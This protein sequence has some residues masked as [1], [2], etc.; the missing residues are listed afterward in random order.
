MTEAADDLEQ[1]RRDMR[2]V[3]TSRDSGFRRF[4]DKI[5]YTACGLVLAL[6]GTVWGVTWLATKDDVSDLKKKSQEHAE[7]ITS[8]ETEMKSLR[9][10]VQEVKSDVKLILREV[11]K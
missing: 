1:T 2:R 9:S 4:S 3:D 11:K 10:D 8:T 5:M 7:R 6:V